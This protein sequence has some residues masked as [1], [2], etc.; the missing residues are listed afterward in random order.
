MKEKKSSLEKALDILRLL[1]HEE[2]FMGI[3]EISRN[4]GI[5]KGSVHR[6]LSTLEDNGFV[7]QNPENK[8]YWLGAELYVMGTMVG[9]K[10]PLRDI[11]APFAKQLNE[12]F[13]EVINV[14]ILE[15]YVGNC[16]R[17]LLIYK[18][19]NKHQ[20]LAVYPSIGTSCGCYCSGVGK[21][22]LAFNSS[23]DFSDFDD[24]LIFPYTENTL[25]T[26]DEV[27]KQCEDV[28]KNG[29][30][31]ENEE[32]DYGLICIGVPILNKQ[33]EAIAAI[34]VSGSISRI[35]LENIDWYV[36]KL[37]EAASKISRFL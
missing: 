34:S 31:I 4:L 22:L 1:H 21:C 32:R 7:Q 12:E 10:M 3:S 30:S 17:S 29:Y 15:K 26:W 18:K 33:H 5:S 20:S 23:I 35:K 36:T 16:P 25:K 11:V 13:N 2:N 28:K 6:L 19:V 24:D 14:S 9:D 27:K 8:K 37:K